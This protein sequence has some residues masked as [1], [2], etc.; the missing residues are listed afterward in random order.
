MNLRPLDPDSDDFEALTA[1]LHRAYA[2]LAEMGL[3]FTAT[4]RE[5]CADGECW[6]AE[7]E[8]MI[9]GTVVWGTGAD[10]HDPAPYRE[11]GVAHFNQFA[12]EPT[13]QGTGIGDRLLA[14][15]E[16]RAR[17]AGFHAMTLDT[18]EPAEHLIAFYCRRGYRQIA[19]HQWGDKTYRSVILSKDLR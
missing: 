8:G 1:L 4:T 10:D 17:E 7:R 19:T 18:A 15:I 12:V 14:K 6:V 9:V 11:H 2:R 5:R 3:N 16:V 13:L